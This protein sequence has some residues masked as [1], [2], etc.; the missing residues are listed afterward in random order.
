MTELLRKAFEE[1]SKLPPG[2]QDALASALLDEL[3]EERRWDG[4]LEQTHEKLVA[5]ADAALAEH[6]AGKTE[7]LDPDNL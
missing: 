3:E 2:E 5:L 4:T 1:G 6:R 7:P